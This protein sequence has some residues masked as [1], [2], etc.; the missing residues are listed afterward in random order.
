MAKACVTAVGTD[1]RLGP[2]AAKLGPAVELL[3]VEPRGLDARALVAAAGRSQ[4]VL[5]F[6]AGASV[7]LP[8]LVDELPAAVVVSTEAA[9]GVGAWGARAPHY[10]LP[11]GVGADDLAALI[12]GALERP[13]GAPLTELVPAEELPALLVAARR[14]AAPVDGW[15]ATSIVEELGVELVRADRCRCLFFDAEGGE[16]WR[17]PD[18]GSGASES[19]YP[20]AGL[21]G[22]VARTGTALRCE[23]LGG[24]ARFVAEI[25]APASGGLARALIQPVAGAR[26][27]AHA[28][29]VLVRDAGGPAFSDRDLAVAEHLAEHLAA[30]LQRHVLRE[31]EDT[32]EGAAPGLEALGCLRTDAWRQHL[33]RGSRGEL[34]RVGARWPQM[35]LHL[36]ALLLLLLGLAAGLI[37]LPSYAAGPGVVQARARTAVTAPAEGTVLALEVQPGES[38]AAGQILARLHAEREQARR[39]QLEAR[40]RASL[41]RYLEW[42]DD[43]EVQAEVLELRAALDEANARL[44]ERAIRAPCSGRLVD[45]DVHPGQH[46]DAGA[47]IGAIDDGAGADEIVAFLPGS[48]APR[49]SPGMELRLEVEGYVRSEVRAEILAVSGAALGAEQARRHLGP[50]APPIDLPPSVV[51]VRAALHDADAGLAFDGESLLL[52]DG[53]RGRAEVRTHRER[54][55]L[56]L[57]PQLRALRRRR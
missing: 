46:L 27:L 35:V 18:P 57:M 45:L 54:L 15:T 53:M 51:V 48:A 23:E 49:L 33:A 55:A 24:E 10:V 28:V 9:A 3:R 12:Q 5:V 22:W 17:P 56:A 8:R 16:L 40:W 11:P 14:L 21:S 32:L 37:Q 52:H 19:V 6:D 42:P 20:V 44:D 36:A 25:D 13:R 29:L 4:V 38:V 7:S 39:D 43:A 26:G 1:P 30:S 41:R 47:A 2:L 31:A 50:D 34:L